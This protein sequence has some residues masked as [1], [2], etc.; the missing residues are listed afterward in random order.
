MEH[1]QFSLEIARVVFE[2]GEVVLGSGQQ[3]RS[4]LSWDLQTRWPLSDS[5][6]LSQGPGGAGRRWARERRHSGDT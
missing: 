5:V 4:V 1:T 3:R 2:I 6:K